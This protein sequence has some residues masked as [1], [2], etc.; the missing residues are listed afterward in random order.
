[1]SVI[2]LFYIN[3]R[4]IRWYKNVFYLSNN[5]KIFHS[6][7]QK[8]FKFI[9]SKVSVLYI[10]N[11]SRTILKNVLFV[12]FSSN[13]KNFEGNFELRKRKEKNW[14]SKKLNLNK[15]KRVC[16]LLLGCDPPFK[17]TG[18]LGSLL[19]KNCFDFSKI[20]TFIKPQ[21]MNWKI[22]NWFEQN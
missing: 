5:L 22:E 15:G 14:K 4:E 7:I 2:S 16:F 19:K 1:M 17:R 20:K 10:L 11:W 9:S 6:K 18:L 13:N 8:L 12:L 3:I 21:K